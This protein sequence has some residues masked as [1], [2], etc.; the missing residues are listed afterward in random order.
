MPPDSTPPSES[1]PELLHAVGQIL[2]EHVAG[3]DV[4]TLLEEMDAALLQQLRVH[5]LIFDRPMKDWLKRLRL[6]ELRDEDCFWTG[7]VL[8]K[9]TEEL[10]KRDRKPS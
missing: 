4:G 7:M 9:I 10:E 5:V 6:P 2:A 1:S 8:P 3:G